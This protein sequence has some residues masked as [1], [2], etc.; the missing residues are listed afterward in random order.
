LGTSGIQENGTE[1]EHVAR[2]HSTQD[3]LASFVY[4]IR[5]GKKRKEMQTVLY[6]RAQVV[7]ETLNSLLFIHTHWY[8]SYQS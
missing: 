4:N 3:Y 1:K 2:G 8:R 7:K 5:K 6:L